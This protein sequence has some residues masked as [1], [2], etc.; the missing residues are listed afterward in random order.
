MDKISLLREMK[1]STLAQLEAADE[2]FQAVQ[3]VDVLL[4][5]SDI[6]TRKKIEEPLRKIYLSGIKIAE[7]AR[8]S[9]TVFMRAAGAE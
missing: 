5:E 1:S 7:K 6:A 4:K 2:I 3:A 9:G 8:E